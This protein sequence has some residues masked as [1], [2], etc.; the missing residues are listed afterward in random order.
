MADKKS[1][2]K[3]ILVIAIST[4]V[5]AAANAY[6]IITQSQKPDG[7]LWDAIINTVLF[8]AIAVGVTIHYRNR[9]RDR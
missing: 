7:N 2:P 9:K 6:R 4:W 8:A 5:G 3:A 1:S